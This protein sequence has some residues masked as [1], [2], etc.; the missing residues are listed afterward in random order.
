MM[1]NTEDISNK[2]DNYG[3]LEFD[4]CM[5]MDPDFTFQEFCLIDLIR[6]GAGSNAGEFDPDEYLFNVVFGTTSFQLY[7]DAWEK[8]YLG[9]VNHPAVIDKPWDQVLVDKTNVKIDRNTRDQYDEIR[10][11]LIAEKI[12]KERS[13]NM[14]KKD[15]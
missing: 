7:K 6:T 5:D 4:Y 14:E 12:N 2:I 8:Y 13:I 9:S 10:A 11:K 15:S 3:Y 1:L